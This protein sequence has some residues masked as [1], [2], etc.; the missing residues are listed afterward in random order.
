MIRCFK[1]YETY[2]VKRRPDRL[3]GACPTVGSYAFVLQGL[4][5]SGSK[6]FNQDLFSAIDR[7]CSDDDL[8]IV[9]PCRFSL[10]TDSCVHMARF[11]PRG[12]QGSL[13]LAARKQTQLKKHRQRSWTLIVLNERQR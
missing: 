10:P 13:V 12:S 7:G 6:L 4:L 9:I 1:A 3:H 11:Y 8:R 2:S 5:E